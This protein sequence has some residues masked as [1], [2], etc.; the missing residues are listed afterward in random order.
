MREYTESNQEIDIMVTVH[1]AEGLLIVRHWHR[2]I[3][4]GSDGPAT[5]ADTP[6][7]DVCLHVNAIKLKVGLTVMT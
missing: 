4:E 6:S 7:L 3:C 2:I 1:L 5:V